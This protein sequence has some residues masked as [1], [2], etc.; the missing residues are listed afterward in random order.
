MK[1]LL[2]IILF[3]PLLLTAKMDTLALRINNAHTDQKV[4]WSILVIKERMNMIFNK[5][6]IYIS[7]HDF[8]QVTLDVN[9]YNYK[10]FREIDEDG[11]ESTYSAE[12]DSYTINICVHTNHFYELLAHEIGH[13]L[14]G[15]KHNPSIR[16]LMYYAPLNTELSPQNREWI[17]TKKEQFF[18]E[19]QEFRDYICESIDKENIF[20]IFFQSVAAKRMYNMDLDVYEEIT[21]VSLKRFE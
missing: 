9:V 8:R 14:F 17:R 4:N 3:V 13:F 5:Y 20:E 1:K 11:Y 7:I 19:E 10:E 16:Y 15:A 2:I 6:G 12:Y 18:I 21:G